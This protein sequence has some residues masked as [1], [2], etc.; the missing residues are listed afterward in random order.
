MWIYV[1][2]LSY[3]IANGLPMDDDIPE[4][5]A[6]SM[7]YLHGTIVKVYSNIE[8]DTGCIDPDWPVKLIRSDDATEFWYLKYGQYVVLDIP[9]DGRI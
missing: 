5:R 4:G 2:P 7:Q 6:D 3:F 1:Y 8:G 9:E